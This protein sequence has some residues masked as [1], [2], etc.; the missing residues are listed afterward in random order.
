MRRNAGVLLLV[1]SLVGIVFL[2]GCV[3]QPS[4]PPGTTVTT[5]PG[6]QVPTSQVSGTLTFKPTV[7]VTIPVTGVFVKV[8]YL[9]SFNGTY[10][11]AGAMQQ[12]ISSGERVYE[13]TNATGSVSATF[14]KQDDST[15][16][17]I[18]VELW[19]NGALLTS[20]KNSTSFGKVSITSV[21]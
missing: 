12:V 20:Q 3:G 17:E 5:V 10:G 9:G 7:Q 6:T 14:F 11:M 19:K 16:H 18:A 4:T 13:I 21:V 15:T 8:S 2:S 1:L